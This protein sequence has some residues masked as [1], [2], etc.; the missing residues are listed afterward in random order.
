MWA[1]RKKEEEM[2]DEDKDLLERL[3]VHSP[4]LKVVYDLCKTFT[5]I[6]DKYM[7]KR[8]AKFQRKNWMKRV[9]DSA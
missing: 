2:T 4:Q 8:R 5:E 1:L 9:K 7:T 6:F 3:F